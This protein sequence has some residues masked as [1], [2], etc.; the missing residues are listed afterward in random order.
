MKKLS[1]FLFL[2]LSISN[3]YSQDFYTLLG[4]RYSTMDNQTSNDLIK[5]DSYLDEFTIDDYTVT[6]LAI[7]DQSGYV[8]GLGYRQYNL[9]GNPNMYSNYSLKFQEDN[10]SIYLNDDSGN[11]WWDVEGWNKLYYE[12]WEVGAGLGY[13]TNQGLSVEFNA[14]YN[15]GVDKYHWSFDDFSSGNYA[16]FNLKIGYTIGAK[17]DNLWTAPFGVHY[18]KPTNYRFMGSTAFDSRNLTTDTVL[19]ELPGGYGLIGGA[20]A[21]V[22]AMIDGG[23]GSDYDYSRSSGYAWDKHYGANNTLIWRCRDKSNGQWA[24]NSKCEGKPKNDNTWPGYSDGPG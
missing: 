21:V 2:V 23:G 22:I 18:S 6:D 7:K 24:S 3:L 14:G 10:M 12:T 19:L 1:L 8:V 4:L 17:K 5:F 15:M 13:M 9:F 16:S 20:V 11:D